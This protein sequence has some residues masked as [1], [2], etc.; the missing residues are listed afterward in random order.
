[1][2]SRYPALQIL[3]KDD[4]NKIKAIKDVHRAY[5][6]LDRNLKS[7]LGGGSDTAENIA[8]ATVSVVA[9]LA[10]SRFAQVNAIKALTRSFGQFSDERVN[11][12]MLRASFDSDYAQTLIN[13]A[14]NPTSQKAIKRFGELMVLPNL[15]AEK[16]G[17]GVS[18][19]I[20][21]AIPTGQP[22][23]Q[24]TPQITQ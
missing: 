14:K 11:N 12:Y 18:D 3:Y 7:P 1:M 23:Q 22:Q 4:P 6:M 8:N 21:A 20:R 10:T 9:P 13:L 2:I 16:A 24:L 19:F 15:A 17:V 5:R